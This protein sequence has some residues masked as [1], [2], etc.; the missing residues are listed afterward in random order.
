MGHYEE[1]EAVHR[2]VLARRQAML[3]TR[4][5]GHPAQLCRPAPAARPAGPGRG[6]RTLAASRDRGHAPGARRRFPETLYTWTSL[7]RSCRSSARS[8][9]ATQSWRC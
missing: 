3:G 7:P 8:G 1:S 9:N 5:P 2:Q 6:G 4:P